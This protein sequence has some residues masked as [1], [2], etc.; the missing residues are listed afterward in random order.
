MVLSRLPLL[1]IEEVVDEGERVVMRA[2]MPQEPAPFPVS[3]AL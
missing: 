3:G 1:A 2:R